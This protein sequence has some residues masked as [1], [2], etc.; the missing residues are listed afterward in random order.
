[1]RDAS[2]AALHPDEV[3]ELPEYRSIS[4]VAVIGLVLALFS[5]LALGRGLLI[6]VP[7]VAGFLCAIALI[8]IGRSEGRLVGSKAAIIGLC[9]ATFFA[10]AVPAQ[11][12][13]WRMGLHARAK[14]VAL[15]WLTALQQGDPHIAHQLTKPDLTRRSLSGNLW[16]FYRVD[17]AARR[18]LEEF[19]SQ[20]GVELLLTLGE[21][22]EI[23]YYEPAEI[24]ELSQTARLVTQH[25]AVTYEDPQ[26]GRTTF[27]IAVTLERRDPSGSV[28]EQ[29][30]VADY[31][32]GV[33]P[34][35]FTL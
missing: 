9:L 11:F 22:A 15:A 26:A 10:A 8:R 23:R 32:S 14:P 5:P 30:R 19:V 1:M 33:R 31:S 12:L 2:D 28:G 6:I 18:E 25:Y 35:G 7:L 34:S 17:Q 27:F 29:W 13:T 21:R 16:E 20:E 4:G 24:V 3:E